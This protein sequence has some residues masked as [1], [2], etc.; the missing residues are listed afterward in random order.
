MAIY[1][2]EK[3]NLTCPHGGKITVTSSINSCEIDGERAILVTD[4][5][6][7]QVTCPN[8]PNAG[9]PCIIVGAQDPNSTPLTSDGQSLATAS[10]VAITQFGPVSITPSNTKAS[11]GGNNT[12]SPDTQTDAQ[13]CAK[14]DSQTGTQTG[15]QAE[16]D[17]KTNINN[18]IVSWKQNDETI[19]SSQE[20]KEVQLSIVVTTD[21]KLKSKD[22]TCDIYQESK[23]ENTNEQ[24]KPIDSKTEK[25]KK[26][27]KNNYETNITWE[28]PKKEGDGTKFYAI[29]TIAEKPTKSSDL[30]YSDFIDGFYFSTFVGIS[31]IPF[32][33]LRDRLIEI[34]TN[35]L[36]KTK[37]SSGQPFAP[38]SLEKH[39]HQPNILFERYID[40]VINSNAA[41]P[42]SLTAST[43]ISGIYKKVPN[44]LSSSILTTL[45]LASIFQ[46]VY[47][48][49]KLEVSHE[50][51]TELW[52]N[53]DIDTTLKREFFNLLILAL[54]CNSAPGAT[55]IRNSTPKETINIEDNFD[56]GLGEYRGYFHFTPWF[57]IK[58]NKI[59]DTGI[60]NKSS[61]TNKTGL[62]DGITFDITKPISACG[63]T[64]IPI[65]NPFT[66]EMNLNHVYLIGGM[67]MSMLTT[68]KS[69]NTNIVD[70]YLKIINSKDLIKTDRNLKN[71]LSILFRK[72][73]NSINEDFFNELLDL[74]STSINFKA[75]LRKMKKT[76]R[77]VGTSSPQKN[78]TW[79]P[80]INKESDSL[81][82]L[83][84]RHGGRLAEDGQDA[85]KNL[86]D[87][88]VPW[89][90]LGANLQL[91]NT[92]FTLRI[93]SSLFPSHALYI[94]SHSHEDKPSI[95]YAHDEKTMQK[96]VS[97][98]TLANKIFYSP[99]NSKDA[100]KFLTEEMGATSTTPSNGIEKIRTQGTQLTSGTSIS[101]L[102]GDMQTKTIGLPIN[103]PMQKPATSTDSFD[104]EGNT[105]VV[106]ET[107]QKYIKKLTGKITFPVASLGHD[108][109]YPLNPNA[110]YEALLSNA[111]RLLYSLKHLAFHFLNKGDAQATGL[112]IDDIAEHFSE[113]SD[114]KMWFA[115]VYY[116][117]TK[118]EIQ[119]IED[120]KY[121]YPHMKLQEVINFGNIYLNSIT[122]WLE[123][124]DNTNIY[125]NWRSAF[126]KAEALNG[127]K[128]EL[129]ETLEIAN[130]LMPSIEAH[131]RFDLPKAISSVYNKHYKG[132]PNATLEDFKLDFFAMSEVFDKADRSLQAGLDRREGAVRVL[133]ITSWNWLKDLALWTMDSKITIAM[134]NKLNNS[135][136][137]LLNDIT[138]ALNHERDIAWEKACYLNTHNKAPSTISFPKD[139]YPLAFN[140]DKDNITDY[141]WIE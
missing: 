106:L 119:F 51:F 90:C 101:S 29:V 140:V 134:R 124:K 4:I 99:K 59:L 18:I 88:N 127:G 94:G 65:R 44:S 13:A 113:K 75:A 72:H 45:K 121:Q 89:I 105:I 62:L 15:A 57:K 33:S 40:Y 115:L 1:L 138:I 131:I 136:I 5:L 87:R 111:N 16:T 98:I 64:I 35:T 2:T 56:E 126:Q 91:Q 6:S 116:Y 3:A 47:T 58:N 114:M 17:K 61:Y 141:P 81:G 28:M 74:L 68:I 27:K 53:E 133:D 118:Y 54:S 20:L 139:N 41:L 109:L 83:D 135:A 137:L 73:G 100:V 48:L 10:T 32:D 8:P 9:G 92:H 77:Y 95:S 46:L 36:T 103:V 19:V 122:L 107:G 70:R 128:F 63:P 50:Y 86:N 76:G 12:N 79:K 38:N 55:S 93:P 108:Y 96:Q 26:I 24:S 66:D 112:R 67:T 117:V 71:N 25:L 132:I 31:W 84:F 125:P 78:T 82:Y 80:V 129:T 69:P 104:D 49:V 130:A 37:R 102:F 110:T 85:A 22:V 123:N 7:A 30:L 42:A 39:K 21:G 11:I 60:L 97:N 34:I 120:K 14:T 23:Q 52:N 43:F